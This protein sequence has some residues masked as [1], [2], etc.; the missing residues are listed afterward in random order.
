MWK[1]W[2]VLN[3][4][5]WNNFTIYVTSAEIPIYFGNRLRKKLWKNASV[6]Y[7]DQTENTWKIC[8]TYNVSSWKFD[9]L[10]LN[11]VFNSKE[12]VFVKKICKGKI[13]YVIRDVNIY[14]IHINKQSCCTCIISL[15]IYTKSYWCFKC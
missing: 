5:I 8:L 10:L 11:I 14:F 15:N 1:Y 7:L 6:S 13:R 9:T 3:A 2:F 4:Q 12:L